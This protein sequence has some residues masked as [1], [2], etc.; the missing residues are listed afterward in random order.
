[1]K[2]NNVLQIFLGSL[3]VLMAAIIMLIVKKKKLVPI[4][5][6]AI[7]LV[8]AIT[9]VIF[10]G[11]NKMELSDTDAIDMYNVY[12]SI[13][14]NPGQAENMLVKKN[15]FAGSIK[16]TLAKARLL[17][18]KGKWEEATALYKKVDSV[19]DSLLDKREKELLEKLQGGKL[20]TAKMLSY[21]VGNANYLKSQGQKPEDY[22]FVELS[23]EEINDNTEYLDKFQKEVVPEIISGVVDELE[24]DNEILSDIGLINAISDKVMSYDYNTYTGSTYSDS[25]ND[26]NSYNNSNIADGQTDKENSTND[27][28][29]ENTGL[30]IYTELL[31]EDA[32][33]LDEDSRKEYFKRL[34]DILDHYKKEYPELFNE[35]QYLEAYIVACVR[36]GN[37]LDDL[38]EDGDT[39]ALQTVMDMYLAGIVTKDD[40]SKDF[41]RDYAKKYKE[42]IKQIKSVERD[43]RSSD[44]DYYVGDL[45][46]KQAVDLLEENNEHILSFITDEIAEKIENN[47]ISDNQLSE[48][49]ISISISKNKQGLSNAS[50]EYFNKAVEK[51]SESDNTVIEEAMDSIQEV[52]EDGNTDTN[53]IDMSEMVANAYTR[54]HHYN[55]ATEQLINSVKSTTGTAISQ[56]AAMIAIGRID[57]EEFSKIKASVVY[58]SNKSLE[59][60]KVTLKDCDIEIKDFDIQKKE[61]DGSEVILLCDVSGSMANSFEALQQAVIQYVESMENNEKVNIITFDESIRQVSGFLSDKNKLIEFAKKNIYQQG[62]TAGA[63]A[64]YSVLDRFSNNDVAKTLVMMTDGEDNNPWPSEDLVSKFSEK[65]S[66]VNATIYTIG[67]GESLDTSYLTTIAN[68]G[69]GR[70]IYCSDDSA[71][72]NAYNFIHKRTSSEYTITFEAEDLDLV[73]RY[74]YIEVND[75][76]N[77][78]TPK[79]L[80]NYSLAGEEDDDDTNVEFDTVL[81]D[82]VTIKGIDVNQLEKKNTAQT[83]NILGSGFEKVK[84]TDVYIESRDG[85]SHCKI[86]SIADDKITFQVAPSVKEGTYSVFVTINNKKYKVDKL[87]IGNANPGEITFGAY[88]FNADNIVKNDNSTVLKGNVRLNDYLYFAGDVE[89]KGNVDKDVS[90]TLSTGSY[91]DV[92]HNVSEYSLIDSIL[93]PAAASTRAFDRIEVVIY[94]D[95]KNYNNYEEYKTDVPWESEI[96]TLDLGIVSLEDN[97]IRIYPDRVSVKSSIGVLKDNTI[98]DLLT[99]GVDFFKVDDLPA[100]IKG[101]IEAEARLMKEGPFTYFNM[102]ISAEANSNTGLKLVDYITLEAKAGAK[103]MFDTYNREIGMGLS[104]STKQEDKHNS[105]D[106]SPYTLCTGDAGIE[107]SI[108]GDENDRR[109][110]DRYLNMSLA[111]PLSITFYVEGIPVTITDLKAELSD[112]NINEALKNIASGRAFSK[113]IKSYLSSKDGAKLKVS[114]AIELIST[115]ALPENVASK[116]NKWLG[117]DVSLVSLD[118]LYGEA[119]INYPYLGAGATLNV[120]GCIQIAEMEMKLGAISYR[121]Y[122]SDL[123]NASDGR[124]HYGFSFLSK[125]GVNFD[126]DLVGTDVGGEVSANV[127]VDRFLIA[128]YAKAKVA[129]NAKISLFGTKIDVEGEAKAEAC[130]GVWKDGKWKAHVTVV[131]SVDGKGSLKFYKLNIAEKEVHE[132]ATI[133]DEEF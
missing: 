131:A 3:P 112:Y 115:N 73:S 50:I 42:V 21:N 19:D 8:V 7:Q 95:G 38:L 15:T 17:A 32:N 132:K 51:G 65:S 46:L 41:T 83:V 49:Y 31:K 116:I 99:N 11:N 123:L 2:M 103:L 71:L 133:I 122:V 59:D 64:A 68:A 48:S 92:R 56:T 44:D 47:E 85:S 12:N 29:T 54:S 81:P 91:A 80:K 126:W 87:I 119:G 53:Y 14:T 88:T 108:K 118:D 125:Q 77:T 69:A 109:Y 20:F 45:K 55:V 89:L 63:D 62:G 82:G 105:S 100:Y 97:Q 35:N 75:D 106:K 130:A 120:L 98:T 104:F 129:A 66:K 30:G 16:Y 60:V 72:T 101:E 113:A 67:L 24:Q 86:K 84:I 26:N 34:Y 40:F 9:A 128:A 25:T 117:D 5:A 94:D 33:E 93:L 22:G 52:Y 23:Q 124:D 18:L 110:G 114:G 107:F 36:A 90:V 76:E 102:D 6:I 10:I 4:A 61:Y 127:T 27:N 43:L 57:T 13:K 1:M 111:L 79:D 96:G 78:V 37:K 39:K 28:E 58:S 70:F 74:L 121:D